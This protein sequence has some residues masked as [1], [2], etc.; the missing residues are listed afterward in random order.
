MSFKTILVHVDQSK[1]A[2][3]RIRIAGVIA[4]ENDAYLV[5][6]ALTGNV[7]G[8]AYAG[9][10]M[11]LADPDTA[12]QRLAARARH[13]CPGGIR[14]PGCRHGPDPFRK[15]SGRR[16]RMGRHQAPRALQT[17]TSALA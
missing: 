15:A 3:E 11:D 7:S 12:A 16:C 4:L 8:V 2:S 6:L 5:G 1:H 17:R 13:P 9:G 10:D 14:N